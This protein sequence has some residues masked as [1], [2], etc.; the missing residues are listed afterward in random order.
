MDGEAEKLRRREE[1]RAR[2]EAEAAALAAAEAEEA[3]AKQRRREERRARKEAEAAANGTEVTHLPGNAVHEE[4]EE[5]QRRREERRARKQAEAAAAAADGSGHEKAAHQGATAAPLNPA[6]AL[7]QALSSVKGSTITATIAAAAA[8]TTLAPPSPALSG[9]LEIEISSFMSSKWQRCWCM[10][11]AAPPLLP[12]NLL[13][14]ILSLH[15]PNF[16]LQFIFRPPRLLRPLLPGA[17]RCPPPRL[18]PIHPRARARS[19]RGH[20]PHPRLPA[21][22]LQVTPRLFI[23]LRNPACLSIF[24]TFVSRRPAAC[25]CPRLRATASLASV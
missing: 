16:S 17:A 1:R 22:G 14:S 25:A 6:D 11:V 12:P 13:I 4:E 3:A 7:K 18:T 9:F 24:V 15:S 20:Q 21:A 8:T 10:C 23:S 19:S 5:K 2:K